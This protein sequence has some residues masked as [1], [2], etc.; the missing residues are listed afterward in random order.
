MD[1]YVCI[2]DYVN[3]YVL[4][5]LFICVCT[6]SHLLACC[7]FCVALVCKPPHA[8]AVELKKPGPSVHFLRT[9]LS[10]SSLMALARA[11]LLVMTH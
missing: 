10:I 5:Y 9:C 4:T 7:H 11:A 8:S 1:I 3:M 2:I 6:H